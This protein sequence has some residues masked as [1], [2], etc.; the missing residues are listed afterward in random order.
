MVDHSIAS[1]T[2]A[3]ASPLVDRLEAYQART[4]SSGQ[5]PGRRAWRRPSEGASH[6]ARPC[7]PQEPAPPV[8]SARSAVYVGAAT[9]NP[10]A[11]SHNYPAGN[12]A[13]QARVNPE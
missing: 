10:S 11:V 3:G 8:G 12:P 9:L 4:A 7:S 5:S 2:V 1:R 6:E 13:L